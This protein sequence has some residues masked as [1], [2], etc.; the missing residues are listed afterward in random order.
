[1]PL[2]RFKRSV[3]FANAYGAHYGGSRFSPKMIRMGAVFEKPPC[4]GLG[5]SLHDVEQL[6]DPRD[7]GFPITI[8]DV[9]SGCDRL[10]Q[11]A[12]AGC[13][14][15][16]HRLFRRVVAGRLSQLSKAYLGM[17]GTPPLPFS[18]SEVSEAQGGWS[19]INMVKRLRQAIGSL[20]RH[21]EVSVNGKETGQSDGGRR[22]R[23]RRPGSKTGATDLQLYRNWKDANRATGI[24]KA[25]FIRERGLP[26]KDLDAI[27]RGRGQVKRRSGHK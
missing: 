4:F 20:A 11:W 2:F 26:E 23:G 5:V 6:P 24:T 15:E 1:M 16:P 21:D 22:R 13:L 25:E 3:S 8:A 14:P 27:E 19:L 17:P 18:P 12:N 7:D 9:G 10:L